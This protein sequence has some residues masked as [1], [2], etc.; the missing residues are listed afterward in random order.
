MPSS[1]SHQFLSLDRGNRVLTCLAGTVLLGTSSKYVRA[2]RRVMIHV[3]HLLT[4][5]YVH[6]G[7]PGQKGALTKAGTLMYTLKIFNLQRTR[8][9]PTSTPSFPVLS[10][11][12]PG[13]TP[14]KNSPFTIRRGPIRA[15]VTRM[16][17]EEREL[18]SSDLMESGD[19]KVSNAVPD[20]FSGG[21]CLH[22]SD[23]GTPGNCKFDL[24]YSSHVC[25][26][27]L[28]GFELQEEKKKK[29]S[30]LFAEPGNECGLTK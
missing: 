17:A 7:H 2:A 13:D 16:C 1:S 6:R 9:T 26:W 5:S 25:L 14:G 4:L 22:N 21:W 29:E 24:T 8:T 11:D 23:R 18:F 27:R 19:T 30:Q 10:D 20:R 28:G 3:T 15:G 12:P